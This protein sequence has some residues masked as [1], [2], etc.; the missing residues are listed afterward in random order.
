MKTYKLAIKLLQY[1]LMAFQSID[2]INN[3]MAGIKNK[4]CKR[5]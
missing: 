5:N 4:S 2:K 1:I 3:G